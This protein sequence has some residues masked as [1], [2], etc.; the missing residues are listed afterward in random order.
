MENIFTT[1]NST[2]I[3]VLPLP[4]KNRPPY[5][6]G[7][8][9]RFKIETSTAT[10]RVK[11]GDPIEVQIRIIGEGEL[12]HVERPLLSELKA[13]KEG[14]T[15]VEN[16]QPGDL[17]EDSITFTQTIR[18]QNT[19]TQK[20]PK[21]PFT[22]FN[23]ERAQYQTVYSDPI[24]LKVLPARKVSSSDINIYTNREKSES[25][26]LKHFKK[27]LQ[28]NYLFEN[29]LQSQKPNPYWN[30]Y[31]IIPPLLYIIM[32]SLFSYRK[33]VKEDKT[34][35]KVKAAKGNMKKH[36]KNAH[37]LL[38]NETAEFF[39]ELSSALTGYM[40]AK[41]DYGE[42]AIT[43]LDIN[44]LSL[45]HKIPD[46][47]ARKTAWLMEEFDRIRYTNMHCTSEDKE[48]LYQETHSILQKIERSL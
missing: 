29:A 33:G 11:V 35:I 20:I 45:E 14:F 19:K 42:N 16:L 4:K 41:L 37:S 10:P 36:L 6:S 1:S 28:G 12:G 2:T 18:A 15:I 5:F 40:S 46:G 26:D 21:L 24:K 9:G 23:P 32:F 34:H 17:K 22:F 30:L 3:E 39:D 44:K 38:S 48:K 31:L 7:A 8:V 13:F 43:A 25:I 47:L 27:G